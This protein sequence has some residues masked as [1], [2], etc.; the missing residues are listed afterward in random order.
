MVGMAPLAD[1]GTTMLET[2][3]EQPRSV[4]MNIFIRLIPLINRSHAPAQAMII[5]PNGQSSRTAPCAAHEKGRP[6]R[7]GLKKRP[8]CYGQA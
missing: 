5:C 3:S 1:A 4:D 6:R 2:A 7:S 8:K